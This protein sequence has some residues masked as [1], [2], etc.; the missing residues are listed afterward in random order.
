MVCHSLLVNTLYCNKRGFSS[1]RLVFIFAIVL[2]QLRLKDIYY[3]E[4]LSKTI[5]NKD[6]SC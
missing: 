4:I 5:K 1:E 2:L 6:K 3:G